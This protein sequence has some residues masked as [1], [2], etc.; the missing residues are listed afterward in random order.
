MREIGLDST[1]AIFHA[2]TSKL[3][4]LAEK[5]VAPVAVKGTGVAEG[6]YGTQQFGIPGYFSTILVR[7]RR[8][9]NDWSTEETNER[10]DLHFSEVESGDLFWIKANGTG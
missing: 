6:P 8:S 1:S 10:R 5:K 3:R 2:A 7:G 4:A 9:F